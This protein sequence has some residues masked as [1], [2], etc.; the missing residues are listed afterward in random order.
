MT[1][2]TPD[3]DHRD[4]AR[5]LTAREREILLHVVAGK[6]NREIA[7]ELWLSARTVQTHLKNA[8]R[9]LGVPNRTCLAVAALRHGIVP[10][11]PSG[12][13]GTDDRRDDGPGP[14]R[15]ATRPFPRRD[16]RHHRVVT[17]R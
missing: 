5:A 11:H 8:S 9:K 14:R 7:G 3:P 10:L 13:D 1:A 12:P 4:G 17:L 16:A 2:P 15:R 6:S